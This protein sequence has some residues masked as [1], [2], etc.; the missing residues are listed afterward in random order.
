MSN[1]LIANSVALPEPSSMVNNVYMIGD[2]KRNASGIMNVQYI[3]TKRKYN[4]K[5]GTMSASQLQNMLSIIK[6]PTPLYSLTVLD[7]SVLGG[8]YT[9]IFYSGDVVWTSV[10][11]DAYGNVTFKD[12]T[13]DLIEQ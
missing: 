9:G 13:I 2:S 8:S 6:S 11:I 7:S 3:A 5:W 1:T 4:T 10:K 12:I